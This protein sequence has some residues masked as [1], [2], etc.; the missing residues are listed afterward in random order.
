[1]KRVL[2]ATLL[3][4][5]FA[6]YVTAVVG[7]SQTQVPD[8]CQSADTAKLSVALN[9]SSTGGE[10][11]PISGTTRIKVCGFAASVAGTTPSLKFR[12]GTGSVCGTGTTELT[13]VILPTAGAMVS[14]TTGGTAFATPNGQA[15]CVLLAGTTP[16]VQGVLTYVR[17]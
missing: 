1:M 8:P 6:A 16:S 9:L 13:G 3:A 11:L 4:A 2:F 5:T 7:R 12:Y 15:L 14:Y 10:V 17:Q